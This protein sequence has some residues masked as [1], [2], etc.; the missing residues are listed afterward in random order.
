MTV[1]VNGF[2]AGIFTQPDQN[3][4]EPTASGYDPRRASYANIRR[5]WS[6]G[7]VVDIDLSFSIQHRS[8]HP[9]VKGHAGKIAITYGPLVY[10]LESIDNPGI[11]L[12]KI[13]IDTTTLKPRYLENLLGGINSIEG[14]TLDGMPLLF[15]PYFLWGNRGQSA[16]TVWVNT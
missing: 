16:M 14:M 10:C 4:L 7:D 13:R 12:F 3:T 9:R 2:P 8:A 15:I 11:D 6:A 1:S 5:E